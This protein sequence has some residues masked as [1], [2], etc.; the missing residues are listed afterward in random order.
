M[1]KANFFGLCLA[2]AGLFFIKATRG[3][4]LLV[5]GEFTN[6]GLNVVVSAPG[7]FTNRVEIYACSN[8]ASGT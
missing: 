5:S 8:L 4:D 3:E 7:G 2:V 1:K 6:N